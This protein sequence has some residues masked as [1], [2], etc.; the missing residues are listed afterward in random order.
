MNLSSLV[1]ENQTIKIVPPIEHCLRANG[2]NDNLDDDTIVWMKQLKKSWSI[3]KKSATLQDYIEDFFQN[4]SEP[5]RVALAIVIKFEDYKECKICSLPYYIIEVLSKMSLDSAVLPDEK[6]KFC[7]FQVAIQQNNHNFIILVAKTYNISMIKYLTL[8]ELKKMILDGNYKLVS[9]I[10]SALDL[11][12]EIPVQDILFPLVMQDKLNLVYQYLEQCPGEVKPFL[13]YMDQL[14]DKNFNILEFIR[15]YIEEKKVY[16]IKYDKLHYK[17][18]GK[19]VA[20]L[21]ARFDIPIT[22]FKNLSKNRTSGGL[23]YLVYQ[24]YLE[25]NLS[26]SVWDDLVKD[27][28]DRN[29]DSAMEFV[30]FLAE[31]D[32]KEAIKWAEYLNIPKDQYPQILKDTSNS[33]NILENE[34][35][36][37]D[38]LSASEEFYKFSLSTNAIILIDTATTFD[39]FI[40]NVKNY[41]LLGVDCEWKPSFGVTPVKLA[42]IQISTH[43][44]VYLLDSLSLN[45]K[46]F[47]NL[48][49]KFNKSILDNTN[50]I[51]IGFGIKQ[52]LHEMK[53]SI[54]GLSNI[55]IKGEALLDL[56]LLWKNLLDCGLQLP[57]TSDGGGSL[58]CLV[59]SCFNKPLE[60]TEQCSNWELRP[61]RQSQIEYAALDAY[62]LVEIYTLLQKLSREQGIEFDDICND[63]ML[64][65]KPKICKKEVSVLNENKQRLVCEVKFFV[66]P[67][68][69]NL[70]SHLRYIG[71]N[72]EIIS[73]SM[74]WH[75]TINSAI[76]DDRF[77]LVSKAKISSTTDFP[78]NHILEISKHKIKI[79]LQKIITYFGI[80]ISKSDFLTRCIYCNK[81]NLKKLTTDD[82]LNYYEHSKTKVVYNSNK[83]F[84]NFDDESYYDN[85]LSDSDD[86]DEYLYQPDVGKLE[87]KAQCLT[88]IGVPIILD[89]I[90]SLYRSKKEAVLCQSCGRILWCGEPLVKI[91]STLIEKILR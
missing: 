19:F 64:D 41:T 78:Q 82:I 25:N 54:V 46:E 33:H 24:K 39:E 40:N 88:E 26:S 84:D 18:L 86:D 85:F 89:Q 3:W 23:R 32:K 70:V 38:E 66:E 80:N 37:D 75:E 2:F 49:Y 50:I 5:Y 29:I 35:N 1:N 91:T 43:D 30:D 21:C 68:L 45:K 12:E 56:S 34:E 71:L 55:K 73:S 59:Q 90:E 14:L 36:W 62:V 7:A 48:W 53:S 52:D 9:Q 17:P 63:V 69:S 16:N 87:N 57:Y 74:L 28:L 58:C 65:T 10:V 11:C 8:P 60:K 13:Q 42:V 83:Q 22:T 81:V 44:N 6:L 61:L 15:K 77:I 31:Y 47:I 67:K 4:S 72:S 20:K 79:Q 76:M 27:A 51:K